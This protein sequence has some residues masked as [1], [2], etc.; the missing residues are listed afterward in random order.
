M[1]R[2][3]LGILMIFLLSSC[4]L[5]TKL[6][7]EPDPTPKVIVTAEKL[8]IRHAASEQSN[9]QFQVDKDSVL[10]ILDTAKGNEWYHI[11]YQNKRGYASVK[12]VENYTEMSNWKE[13]WIVLGISF[14]AGLIIIGGLKTQIADGRYSDGTRDGDA[15]FGCGGILFLGL[16]IGVTCSLLW[17]KFFM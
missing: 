13:F 17:V 5:W 8:N 3:F 1:F 4:E 16:I 7:E 2:L 11:E 12:Y 15:V 10:T 14:L 9:V 6:N